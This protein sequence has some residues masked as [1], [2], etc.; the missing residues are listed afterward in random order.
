MAFSYFWNIQTQE[1]M[2]AE[3]IVIEKLY[4]ASPA[5]IWEALTNKDVMKQWYFDLTEFKPEVGFEFRFPGGPD[6]KSYTHICEVVSAV[7]EQQLAYTWRYEGYP[8]VSTLTF[9]LK[10]EDGGTR[11]KLTH[12][13]LET[14]PAD[15]PDLARENFVKGWDYIIPISLTNFLEG[16]KQN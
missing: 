15:N 11:F 13:G 14:F 4:D 7:K 3:P 10:A 6:G 2:N 8:G 5:T 12:E 9:D 1:D 16:K